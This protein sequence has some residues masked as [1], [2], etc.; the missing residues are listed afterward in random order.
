ME[1]TKNKLG[2]LLKNNSLDPEDLPNV[3]KELR[4]N[5]IYSM[6]NKKNR[7]VSLDKLERKL[8]GLYVQIKTIASFISNHAGMFEITF[9]HNETNG[10]FSFIFR[11]QQ[12]SQQDEAVPK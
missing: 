11:T 1:L 9:M 2:E 4:F 6:Q 5:A 10:K 7:S 12:G 3:K 8:E